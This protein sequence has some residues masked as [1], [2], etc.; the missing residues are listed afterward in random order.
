MMSTLGS[1]I[2]MSG[3][4]L[5]IY[6]IQKR[7]PSYKFLKILEPVLVFVGVSFGLGITSKYF[8]CHTTVFKPEI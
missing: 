3:M 5:V 2:A 6:E 4:V 8:L 7:F 1:I